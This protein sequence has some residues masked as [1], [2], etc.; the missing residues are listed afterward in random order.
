M[1]IKYSSQKLDKKFIKDLKNALNNKNNLLL[2]KLLSN[3]INEVDW[4]KVILYLSSEDYLYFPENSIL[5]PLLKYL[6]ICFGYDDWIT[7]IKSLNSNFF[8]WQKIENITIPNNI[9]L[10]S[11]NCL[12]DQDELKEIIFQ[13]RNSIAKIP[14]DFC[15]YTS[16]ESLS[17]PE[18][19]IEIDGF[20]F[21]GCWKLVTLKLP[22]SLVLIARSSIFDDYN[23]KKIIFNGT[24]KQ[25]KTMIEK[26]KSFFNFPYNNSY[27]PT[28]YIIKCTDGI[29]PKDIDYI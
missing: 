25:W 4:E 27:S 23:L 8:S 13:S 7:N 3:P 24:I 26:S 28:N 6:N 22:N 9:L 17:I 18:G 20:A 21:L 11:E 29:A 16:I 15:R 19:T 12:T 1:Y 14:E 5:S 2:K 10:L